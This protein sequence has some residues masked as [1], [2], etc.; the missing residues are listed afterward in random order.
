MNF[1]TFNAEL[2]ELINEESSNDSEY[3][4]NTIKIYKFI[5]YNFA[6]M[7]ENL[8]PDEVLSC[9]EFVDLFIKNIDENIKKYTYLQRIYDKAS[10]AIL[11][12]D[13]AKRILKFSKEVEEAEQT[14]DDNDDMPEPYDDLPNVEKSGLIQSTDTYEGMDGYDN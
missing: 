9:K 12:M 6:K 10:E 14:E 13:V 4:D 7:K 5:C 11:W 1:E 2:A 3:I 8:V